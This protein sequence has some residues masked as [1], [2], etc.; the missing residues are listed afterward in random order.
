MWSIPSLPLLPGPLGT[1]MVVPDRVLFMGQIQLFNHLT[2]YKQMS[3][4]KLKC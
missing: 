2:V 1:G 3:N 4:V